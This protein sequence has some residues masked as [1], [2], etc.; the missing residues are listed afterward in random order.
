MRFDDPDDGSA[1][2][3]VGRLHTVVSAEEHMYWV[4]FYYTDVDGLSLEPTMRKVPLTQE[5]YTIDHK[6]PLGSWYLLEKQ[7]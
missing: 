1:S 5:M 2:W 6:R 4:W 7:S 3:D